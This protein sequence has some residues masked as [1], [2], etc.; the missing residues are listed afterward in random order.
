[1]NK[2]QLDEILNLHLLWLNDGPSGQCANLESANLT[3]ASLAKANLA[4]ANLAKAILCGANLR[5]A[6]FNKE[7]VF[8]D[9]FDPVSRGMRFVEQEEEKEP[10]APSTRFVEQEEEKEPAAPST[11]EQEKA[12]TVEVAAVPAAAELSKTLHEELSEVLA[13]HGL[14]LGKTVTLSINFID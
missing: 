13:K 6:T 2:T 7:T 4:K 3:F 8:P 9:G 11:N 14:T 5:G 1:M 12:E 10:A